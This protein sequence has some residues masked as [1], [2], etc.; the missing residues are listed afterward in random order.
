MI[1]SIVTDLMKNK[2]SHY[3]QQPIILLLMVISFMSCSPK[4]SN[5]WKSEEFESKFYKKVAVVG[6]G[7]TLEA[8]KNFEKIAVE[9]LQKKGINAFEGIEIFP[10]DMSEEDKT[11]ENL[12]RIIHEN[13]V[14]AVIAMKLISKKEDVE[15]T[16]GQNDIVRDR[17]YNFGYYTVQQYQIEKQPVK[18]N[19]SFSYVVEAILHDV[20][21]K[22]SNTD[23]T[24]VWKGQST[25]I[26]PGTPRMAALLFTED[27]VKHMIKKKII[28]T[29]E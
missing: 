13:N 11:P 7:A 3:L 4:L 8:R 5:E 15:I 29:K 1:T 14:D 17:I 19:S 25:L 18:Y 16:G 6:I 9:R 24:L 2:T 20:Q 22:V 27:M 10:A 12:L 26:A 28:L 21:G 23:K